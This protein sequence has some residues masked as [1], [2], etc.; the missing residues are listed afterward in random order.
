MS[1]KI[2]ENLYLPYDEISRFL[3]K[4]PNGMSYDLM[5]EKIP[6]LRVL[7]KKDIA[8]LLKYIESKDRIVVIKR[9]LYGEPMSPLLRHK[10]HAESHLP[11]YVPPSSKDYLPL[12][13]PKAP[14]EQQPSIQPAVVSSVVKEEIK[15]EITATKE[16]PEKVV[17]DV[18]TLRLL[19]LKD[20]HLIKAADAM[21]SFLMDCPNGATR[22]EL[23]NK[24]V[25]YH[26][27]RGKE[28]DIVLS[29]LVSREGIVAAKVD[30][31][32]HPIVAARFIHPL[33]VKP[34]DIGEQR[35]DHEKPTIA[36]D[37][38]VPLK[39]NTVEPKKV[40]TLNRTVRTTRAHF[41]VA[42]FMSTRSCL[43]FYR[44]VDYIPEFAALSVEARDDLLNDLMEGGVLSMYEAKDP[45]TDA[46]ITWVAS[47]DK[48][49][50][51]QSNL[52]TEKL[53]P[54][55]EKETHVEKVTESTLEFGSVEEVRKQIAALKDIEK[56]LEEKE[57]NAALV[58]SI[59]PLR[60]QIV[61]QF[62]AAQEALS[63][64]IDAFAEL[65]NIIGRLNNILGS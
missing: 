29:Y 46:I 40:L 6:S 17:H 9:N 39:E 31:G 53:T 56:E 42:Q 16:T 13:I 7:K 3:E 63:K 44:L 54:P 48:V 50:V 37:P 10:M 61:V 19:H 25:Q 41:I 4:I 49:P 57:K 21:N 22:T 38:I 23:S 8:L 12:P 18:K 26:R 24:V 45:N 32:G 47:S 30:T 65:E 15:V 14:V 27:L 5:L 64:Q 36:L 43:P 1:V 2:P 58:E 34:L 52:N 20:A 60:D 35:F 55:A 59:K 62:N 33:N 51:S 28:R 11:A